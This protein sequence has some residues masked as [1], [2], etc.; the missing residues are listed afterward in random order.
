MMRYLS[1]ATASGEP[2]AEP[3]GLGT[4]LAPGDPVV[5]GEPPEVH[6]PATRMR[7]AARANVW[8]RVVV[9]MPTGRRT[10]GAGSIRPMAWASVERAAIGRG[11][12]DRAETHALVDPQSAAGVLRVDRQ[13]ALGHAASAEER[14]RRDHERAS[15]PAVAPRPADAD[16][17]DPAPSAAEA[18]VLF[19]VDE[20]SNL[21]R[22]PV[23]IP[24][25]PP[26]GRIALGRVGEEALVVLRGSL[27]A[28]P[29]V[30]ERLLVGIPDGP[31]V[32]RADVADLQAVRQRCVRLVVERRADHRESVA[33]GHE[34][35]RAQKGLATGRSVVR[36]GLQETGTVI[37]LVCRDLA[38]AAL[39]R[40]EHGS[41]NAASMPLRVKEAD[42]LVDPVAA[43]LAIPRTPGVADD[44]S[45][46]LHDEDVASR[47]TVGEVL[48]VVGEVFERCRELIA[49]DDPVRIRGRIHPA[50][51]I[52]DT[53]VPE[54]ETP[55]VR[56]LDRRLEP[57]RRALDRGGAPAVH[58]S[59]VK[60]SGLA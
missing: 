6:A 18:A 36:L 15:Q 14:E 8:R 13:G 5:E 22:H 60:S 21:A 19:G 28:A 33:D 47:V 3:L 46:D 38:D 12:V 30:Q 48:V 59:S 52:R 53:E 4:P 26:Q 31:H 50:I 35:G 23:A 17:L 45:T 16:V 58:Q 49:I 10:A 56:Q 20:A 34:P 29:V 44:R 1:S 40:R 25:D 51:V 39:D 43:D 7:I 24:G 11:S 32:L 27:A 55:D 9:S 42:G 37:G 57:I 41:A 54:G 2:L